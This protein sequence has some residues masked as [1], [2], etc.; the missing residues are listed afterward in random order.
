MTRALLSLLLAIG[1]RPALG[2][3]LVVVITVDQ[4][5]PDSLDRYRAQ[6]QGGFAVLLKGGAVFTNA[7]QD[8]AVTETAPGHATILSG[9]VPAHTGIISN[10]QGVQDSTV[11]L[12][13]FSGVGAS[14]ARFRGTALFD[15]LQTAEPAARPLSVSGRDRGAILPLGHAHQQ[16]YRYPPAVFTPSHY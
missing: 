3:R 4:L 16:C 9:R 10:V 7:Y 8:H 11:P 1:L 2:P 5:R 14:P 12:L 15:W 6:L 13:G